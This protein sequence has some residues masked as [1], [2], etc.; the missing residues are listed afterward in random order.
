MQSRVIRVASLPT[1][2][3][4]VLAE[5]MPVTVDVYDFALKLAR[6]HYVAFYDALIAGAALKAGCA[7]LLSED[8]QHERRFGKMIV[9][10]PFL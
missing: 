5:I 8:M 2:F 1:R 7:R 6:D 4:E 10:K 3:C 9:I